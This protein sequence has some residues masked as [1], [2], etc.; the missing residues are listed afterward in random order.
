M[1]DPLVSVIIPVY[2]GGR[3]LAEALDSAFAQTYRPIEVIVVDDG[4]TDETAEVAHSR[5]EAL[6][7]HQENRGVSAA[8]NAGLAIAEGEL[9]ALLDADDVW[10]PDKLCL[11]VDYLSAN[12]RRG[13][14][15]GRNSYFVHPG[16][17]RPTW[18]AARRLDESEQALLPSSWLVRRP[19]FDRVGLFDPSYRVSEDIEWLARAKDAGI[20]PGIVEQVVLRKRLHDANLT[21][22]FAEGQRHMLR[23]LRAS[24]HRQRDSLAL[25]DDHA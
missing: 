3:F 23:A 25:G 1:T 24:V 18:F 2:N 11:Q 5:P 17:A 15:V 10:L 19:T 9:I 16:A 14:V 12:P 13:L 20:V 6:Y 4:S 7:L 22:R 21:G 8:R